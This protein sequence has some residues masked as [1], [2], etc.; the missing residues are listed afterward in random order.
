LHTSLVTDARFNPE[1]RGPADRFPTRLKIS[2]SDQ[3]FVNNDG[4]RVSPHQRLDRREAEVA[5]IDRQI[6]LVPILMGVMAAPP[7]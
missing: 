5:D 1:G 7:P 4:L 3:L 6:N 2:L